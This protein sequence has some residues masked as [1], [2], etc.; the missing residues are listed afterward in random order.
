MFRPGKRSGTPDHSHSPAA[1]RALTGKSVGSSS[2]GGSGDGSGA[3]DEAPV[4]RQT[5]VPVSSQ[6]A[7]K[8]SHWPLKMEGR[9]Q[10]GRELGK[11]HRLEAPRGVA[12][13]LVGGHGDIGQVGQLQRDDPFGIGAGPD[14]VVP[15]VEGP[16]TGQAQIL[17]PRPASRPTRRTL[18]PATGSTARPRS[19]LRSMSAIRWSMSKHP[20]RISSNRAGSML[21][22]AWGRPTTA[23]SPTLG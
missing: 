7:K 3:H 16:Q 5:T 21:H 23:L 10:L 2:K 15:V 11:A 19:R 20:G 1:T 12:P 14:V 13:H 22:S 9:P 18:R 6:A 8:G 4:C 17:V